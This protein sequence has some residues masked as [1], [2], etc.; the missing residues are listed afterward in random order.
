MTPDVRS[1]AITS[2]I[3]FADFGCYTAATLD[4]M[5]SVHAAAGMGLGVTYLRLLGAGDA[6]LPG[7]ARLPDGVRLVERRPIMSE[8][9]PV[10]PGG[11][12]SHLTI[13]EVGNVPFDAVAALKPRVLVVGVGNTL[14][15]ERR[16]ARALGM[17]NA[18][19]LGEVR[20]LRRVRPGQSADEDQPR[21]HRSVRGAATGARASRAAEVL[22]VTAPYLRPGDANALVAGMP[23]A[24]VVAAGRRL[25]GALGEDLAGPVRRVLGQCRET[26]TPTEGPAGTPLGY[27]VGECGTL[28]A[29]ADDLEAIAAGIGP[30]ASELA[31]APFLQGWDLDVR[32]VRSLSGVVDGHP[33]FPPG[34]R[35]RTSELF[36]TDGRTW[37]RTLSRYYRL[38]TRRTV[39]RA[40]K[41]H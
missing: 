4:A 14:L 19:S 1:K 41:L 30:T 7:D 34:R 38:G 36:A 18:P 9:E 2:L 39:S 12:R 24:I 10:M 32:T 26:T 31:D 33:R 15:D 20:L 13:V 11:R 17:V 25:L 5:M 29:L 27:D 37:A 21:F 35:V 28:R 22:A 3:A 6:P 8:P 40:V 16:A 23:P